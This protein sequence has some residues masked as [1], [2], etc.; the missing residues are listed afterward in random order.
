MRSI[1]LAAGAV[2]ALALSIGGPLTAHAREATA[3]RAQGWLVSAY[4]QVELGSV[5]GTIANGSL[6]KVA[7]VSATVANCRAR[8]APRT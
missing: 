3:P 7:T 1:M 8:T 6:L 2:T 4:G 5:G